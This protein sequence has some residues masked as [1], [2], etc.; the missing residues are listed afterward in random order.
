MSKLDKEIINI[1]APVIGDF[2]AEAKIRAIY[3]M[4]KIYEAAPDDLEAIS[5]VLEMNLTLSIGPVAAAS[6]AKEVRAL[7]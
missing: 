6:I 1:L 2:L 4:L 3:Y 7:A 5:Q